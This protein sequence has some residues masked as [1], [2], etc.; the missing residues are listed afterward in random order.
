VQKR[1]H[2]LRHTTVSN[3]LASGV[4]VVTVAS[5]AGHSSVQTTLNTYAHQLAGMKEQAMNKLDARLRA[6]IDRA[7]EERD[8]K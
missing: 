5:I 1:L 7:R 2:D 4:D 6:A 3:L 8:S